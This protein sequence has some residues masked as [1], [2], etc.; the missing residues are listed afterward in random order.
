MRTLFFYALPGRIANSGAAVSSY[1]ALLPADLATP[2]LS[3]LANIARSGVLDDRQKR[4]SLALDLL[5]RLQNA[6]HIETNDLC[7]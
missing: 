5:N 7:H 6:H 1:A 3:R 4:F 2:D